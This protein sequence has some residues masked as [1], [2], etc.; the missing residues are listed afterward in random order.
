MRSTGRDFRL[1][2]LTT[3][4]GN[5]FKQYLAKYINHPAAAKTQ[6]KSALTTFSGS[7]C[8]F[9]QG[10]P[11]KGWA[12]LMGT[13]ASQIYFM[14]A[15]NVEPTRLPQF[16]M[17]GFVNWGSAWPADGNPIDTS[18]DQWFLKQLG[19]RGYIG[20]LSPG[21]FAHLSYKASPLGLFGGGPC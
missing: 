7:E 15:F 11:N 5:L 13:Y 4:S 18:R 20:T 19:G 8:T 16:S 1:N 17:Q 9:G 2:L 14:P 6:G 12:W 3:C 10:T 21:F